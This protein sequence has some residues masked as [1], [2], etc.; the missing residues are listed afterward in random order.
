MVLCLVVNQSRAHKLVILLQLQ[1]GDYRVSHLLLHD[2][3]VLGGAIATEA[4]GAF[5]LD[6]AVLDVSSGAP[7]LNLHGLVLRSPVS[8]DGGEGCLAFSTESLLTE[9]NSVLRS[10]GSQHA[11]QW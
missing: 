10:L 1:V 11:R 8:V 4:G 2:G 9:F 7:R 3:E 6:A 5:G